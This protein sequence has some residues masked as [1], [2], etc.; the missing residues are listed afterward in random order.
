[1]RVVQL[2]VLALAVVHVPAK[3][4]RSGLPSPARDGNPPIPVVDLPLRAKDK[5]YES[6]GDAC[7]ACKFH[8]SSSCAMF[9]TCVC[10]A[11]NTQFGTTSGGFAMKSSDVDNSLVLQCGHCRLEVL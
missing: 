3:L 6:K 2:A 1:M 4:L 7:S 8:A 11:A 5:A 9:K 10:F